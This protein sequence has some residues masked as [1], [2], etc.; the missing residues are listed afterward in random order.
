[1]EKRKQKWPQN[2]HSSFSK[3]GFIYQ[4]LPQWLFPL[5]SDLRVHTS[6]S[7]TVQ[8]QALIFL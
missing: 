1:M 2:T 5:E 7:I 6:I 8:R 3:L 4:Q